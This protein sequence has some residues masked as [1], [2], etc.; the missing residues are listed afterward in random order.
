M[1]WMNLPRF[2]G[3]L[4]LF[5]LLVG[6]SVPAFG[7][8]VPRMSTEK[9]NGLLGAPDL[10]VLDVRANSHWN[11]TGQKIRGAR[12]VDPQKLEDWSGTI[13]REAQVVLY[14]E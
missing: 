10:V 12:R 4:A 14:C 1:N 11:Q 3:A 9:L 6:L 13:G 2:V 8:Q 7:A 5:L